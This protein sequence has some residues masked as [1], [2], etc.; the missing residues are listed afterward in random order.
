MKN[1]VRKCL[2]FLLL[3]H[4]L[5]ASFLQANLQI[6][7]QPD[8]T[9][10]LL[11]I[12][13]EAD[14]QGQMSTISRGLAAL[15]QT[16]LAEY[17]AIQA[18][19]LYSQLMAR[20]NRTYRDSLDNLSNA[21]ELVYQIASPEFREALAVLLKVVVRPS[22]HTPLELDDIGLVTEL[23]PGLPE[24]TV[25]QLHQLGQQRYDAIPAPPE[26]EMTL[27]VGEAD[28]LQELV[29]YLLGLRQLGFWPHNRDWID[30]KLANRQG[31]EDTS[32]A[33]RLFVT[34]DRGSREHREIYKSCQ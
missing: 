30:R 16:V 1:V 23:F 24:K 2:F 15:P 12:L 10:R 13:L 33:L 19:H 22:L 25:R 20:V 26:A 17:P 31:I 14:Q 34:L 6:P 27:P 29:P 9:P 21:Q 7:E 5:Q 32:L 18:A 28:A 3:C 11:S 4:L 8:I